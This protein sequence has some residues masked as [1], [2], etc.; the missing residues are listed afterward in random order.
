MDYTQIAGIAVTAILGI[1]TVNAFV[2]KY[3]TKAVKYVHVA[4]DAI[5]LVDD[6]IAG[7]QDGKLTQ[8]EINKVVADA[9]K[10]KADLQS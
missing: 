9:A 1:G 10:I 5:G 8:D 2:S 3:S 6:I 4:Y 7:L